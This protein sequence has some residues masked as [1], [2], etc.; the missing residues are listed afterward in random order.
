MFILKRHLSV[1][2]QDKGV[3]IHPFLPVVSHQQARIRSVSRPESL[4]CE[5]FSRTPLGPLHRTLWVKL[6][7][8]EVEL[9]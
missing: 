6:I 8:G 5:W 2:H 1:I 9:G 7:L 3:S 4:P